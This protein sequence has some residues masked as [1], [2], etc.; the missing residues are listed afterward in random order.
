MKGREWGREEEGGVGNLEENSAAILAKTMTF[1]EGEN[2]Q[3]DWGYGVEESTH[4][5][6]S[7]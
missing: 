3:L 1:G 6:I 2:T 5:S 4:H 7:L